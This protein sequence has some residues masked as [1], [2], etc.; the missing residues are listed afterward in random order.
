[1]RAQTTEHR[2]GWDNSQEPSPNSL[3]SPVAGV[4]YHSRNKR[5]RTPKI[6]DLLVSFQQFPI[7]RII[8]HSW[9]C[10]TQMPW[11]IY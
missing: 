8:P 2:S 1:M 3:N 4:T 9:A 5:Y 6:S 10:S 11:A 7:G